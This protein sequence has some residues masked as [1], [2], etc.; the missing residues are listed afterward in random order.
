MNAMMNPIAETFPP[1]PANRGTPESMIAGDVTEA[2]RS[3]KYTRW[4]IDAMK[5]RVLR[6]AETWIV[7]FSAHEF[8]FPVYSMPR[9]IHN[10]I[11][12]VVAGKAMAA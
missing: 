5:I 1:L 7:C 8:E 4:R 10:F 3:D 11:R 9:D 6:T 12:G 2:F